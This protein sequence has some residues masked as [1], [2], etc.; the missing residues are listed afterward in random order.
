MSVCGVDA[1]VVMR[2]CRC[3]ETEAHREAVPALPGIHSELAL[4]SAAR[5]D[6]STLGSSVA[7][8]IVSLC[9]LP[10]R[11]SHPPRPSRVVGTF[12]LFLTLKSPRL[13]IEISIPANHCL[14]ASVPP[15]AMDDTSF[16]R[17]LAQLKVKVAAML[18][19]V[20]SP[21]A[22]G[23]AHQLEDVKMR[24]QSMQS[25]LD[26]LIADPSHQTVQQRAQPTQSTQPA[27][28]HAE[29][30]LPPGGS[31][32]SLP[33][34]PIFWQLF[35]SLRTDMRGLNN[36]VAALE[37]N[38]S[39]LEDRVDAL[40]PNNHTPAASENDDSNL[41]QWAQNFPMPSSPDFLWP[42][43][44]AVDQEPFFELQSNPMNTSA[45]PNT[46]MSQCAQ[47]GTLPGSEGVA[48]RDR[49]I[50]QLEELIRQTQDDLRRNEDLVNQKDAQ[51]A[52][53]TRERQSRD[54]ANYARIAELDRIGAERGRLA[55]G[56][57]QEIQQLQAALQAKDATL[58]TRTAQQYALQQSFLRK[59]TQ[60]S[61]AGRHVQELERNLNELQNS[62]KHVIDD[63]TAKDDQ[64]GKLRDFCEAK[65][66]LV[67][68]QEQIIERGARIIEERDEEIGK[69]SRR[70]QI[71]NDDYLQETRERERCARL[72]DERNDEVKQLQQ[73][74][75]KA[76]MPRSSHRARS[77]RQSMYATGSAQPRDGESLIQCSPFATTGT[78]P[79]RKAFMSQQWTPQAIDKYVKL[80]HE[81]DRECAW[82]ELPTSRYRF[83]VP[84]VATPP[85]QQ[86]SSKTADGQKRDLRRS[87]SLKLLRRLAL[88]EEGANLPAQTPC[89]TEKND[90]I[91]RQRLPLDDI[92]RPPLPAPLPPRPL[93]TASFADL[94]SAARR[95]EDFGPESQRPIV[96]HQSIQDLPGSN[97]RVH[98]PYV[99]E[100]EQG[101]EE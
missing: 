48:F 36:R 60:L 77:E 57:Q 12:C 81:Q 53:F 88:V 31:R 67:S 56:L 38:Y 64:I 50:A 6:F 18:P 98:Q 65:E 2:V 8:I 1:G 94:G 84:G 101:G 89:M 83:G 21:P 68:Q 93:R 3:V 99:E 46:Y 70:I 22:D 17:E 75:T 11:P 7:V 82:G 19:S 71:L 20:S 13:L 69:L 90:R 62:R 26:Y 61:Q 97:S 15:R 92:Y 27:E 87:D 58:Q 10:R 16:Q 41:Q 44:A 42:A 55:H 51:L 100:G 73:S 76:L 79:P 35:T 29:N 23:F 52:Q 78:S 5:L 34:G 96:K 39:D 45:V 49:E 80:P 40:D 54:C 25:S 63:I 74:L 86:Q 43:E 9:I 24:L 33:S 28:P 91:Q 47:T 32:L 4:V 72:L 85:T 66:M 95:D 14:L 59:K 37:L 30:M